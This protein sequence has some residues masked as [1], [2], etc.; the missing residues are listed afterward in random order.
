MAVFVV[1]IFGVVA[2]ALSFPATHHASHLVIS[3]D[4]ALLVVLSV[5]AE[6][7]L[8]R[9]NGNAVFSI[10][11]YTDLGT[12]VRPTKFIFFLLQPGELIEARIGNCVIAY[13]ILNGLVALPISFVKAV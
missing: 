3:N 8:F 5:P 1:V 4:E 11:V 7:E 13:I 10:S 9:A 2:N 6:V 12:D